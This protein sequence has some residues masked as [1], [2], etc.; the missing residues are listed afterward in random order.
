[1]QENGMLHAFCDLSICAAHGIIQLE[2]FRRIDSC[3]FVGLVGVALPV[4]GRDFASGHSD[5]QQ[6]LGRNFRQQLENTPL[7][8]SFDA[9]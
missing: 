8:E 2:N 9:L 1:M 7:L 6:P 3:L 4:T 5:G